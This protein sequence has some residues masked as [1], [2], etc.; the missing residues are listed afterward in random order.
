MQK[1]NTEFYSKNEDAV[2]NADFK[3]QVEIEANLSCAVGALTAAKSRLGSVSQIDTIAA[4]MSPLISIIRVI[5]SNICANAPHSSHDLIELS[6][7][8]GSIV[9]DSG[10][11]TEAKFD[12]RQTNLESARILDEVNLIAKSKIRTQYPNLNF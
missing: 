3:K 8:L 2:K 9:M 12:F 6:T 7:T 5:N 11:L 10:S 1:A 4:T